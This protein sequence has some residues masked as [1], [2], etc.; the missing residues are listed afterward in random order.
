MS[1][2]HYGELEGRR[3]AKHTLTQ[4]QMAAWEQLDWF[5]DVLN[6]WK[7]AWEDPSKRL[8]SAQLTESSDSWH[9]AMLIDQSA[10]HQQ[11]R[12][13]LLSQITL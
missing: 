6:G 12:L 1:L 10:G 9:F 5:P 2:L 3:Q 4:M 11:S 7:K 13:S 8:F